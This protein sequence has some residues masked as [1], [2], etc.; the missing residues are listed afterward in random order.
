MGYGNLIST[1]TTRNNN[2]AGSNDEQK[3]YTANDGSH[4]ISG[5]YI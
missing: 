2:Q 5:K 4:N 1:S 3:S